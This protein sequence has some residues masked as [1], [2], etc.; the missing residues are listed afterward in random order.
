MNTFSIDGIIVSI[1][2]KKSERAP[3]PYIIKTEIKNG[4][5]GSVPVTTKG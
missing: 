4:A 5:T 2:R 3:T 1:G